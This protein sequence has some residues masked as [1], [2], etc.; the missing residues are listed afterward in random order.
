MVWYDIE[1]SVPLSPQSKSAI[2]WKI[3]GCVFLLLAYT[4]FYTHFL[5][6]ARTALF[7]FRSNS[8]RLDV[9]TLPRSRSST[10]SKSMKFILPI[11]SIFL[12]IL[13]C[14]GNIKSATNHNYCRNYVLVK[15]KS[16]YFFGYVTK[17]SYFCININRKIRIWDIWSIKDTLEV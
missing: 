8:S 13:R 17:F 15:E 16:D 12:L 4:H 5:D 6:W 11:C 7:T 3:D 2:V 9:P 10:S 1:V 14:K